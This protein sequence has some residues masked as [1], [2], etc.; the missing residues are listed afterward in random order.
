MPSKFY[1]GDKVLIKRINPR[2]P[3]HLLKELRLDHPRTIVATFYDNK[4][5]H[6]RYYLGTNRRGK[7]DLS[8]IHFRASQLE[9][10]VKKDTGR[11]STRRKPKRPQIDDIY[12]STH[13]NG[14]LLPNLSTR[15]L[16]RHREPQGVLRT[17]REE[18]TCL[19]A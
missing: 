15:H 14:I 3:K 11:P 19:S 6:T 8:F 18:L 1:I 12:T 10:W 16:A 7:T 2:T 5:Q 13:L 4:T 9:L 17:T